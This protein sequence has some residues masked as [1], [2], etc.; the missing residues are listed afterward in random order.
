MTNPKIGPT[1]DYP[2]GKLNEDDEGGLGILVATDIGSGTVRIQFG[3]RISWL[4]MDVETASELAAAIVRCCLE[5]KA[6]EKQ[7]G[8]A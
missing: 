3:K 5:I 2:Q 6:S 7:R 4:G 1:G 8:H